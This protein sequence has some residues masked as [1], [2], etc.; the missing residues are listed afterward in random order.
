[1]EVLAIIPARRGSKGIPKKNSK[2]TKF[3]RYCY[4]L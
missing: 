1:M 4:V 2:N 3:E